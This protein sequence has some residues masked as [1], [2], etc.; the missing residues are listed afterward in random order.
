MPL[1]ARELN[2]LWVFFRHLYTLKSP[3]YF[4][5][6]REKKKR[7]AAQ[8]KN[9]SFHEQ[10]WNWF[11]FRFHFF[12]IQA[13]SRECASKNRVFVFAPLARIRAFM[14]FCLGFFFLVVVADVTSQVVFVH[15]QLIFIDVNTGEC[16]VNMCI[17]IIFYFFYLHLL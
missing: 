7:T 10:T 1:K 5:K 8:V 9:T 17:L 13:I 3:F 2:Q 11:F 12:G 6:W 4:V 15:R 14:G 16:V